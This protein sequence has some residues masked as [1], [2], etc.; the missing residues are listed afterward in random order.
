MITV[1]DTQVMLLQGKKGGFNRTMPNITQDKSNYKSDVELKVV[2]IKL[3]FRGETHVSRLPTISKTTY[4]NRNKTRRKV[5]LV[6][7]QV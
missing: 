5:H 7:N 6:Y 2:R 3:H 4:K 1:Y